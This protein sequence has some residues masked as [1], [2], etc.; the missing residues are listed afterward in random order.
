MFSIIYA[1]IYYSFLLGSQLF[2]LHCYTLKPR[3]WCMAQGTPCVWPPRASHT[4][5]RARST[6][7]LCPVI[8]ALSQRRICFNHSSGVPFSGCC[9]DINLN[10]C[11]LLRLRGRLEFHFKFCSLR[12][13]CGSGTDAS[14][15]SRSRLNTEAPCS[16][17][18]YAAQVK[19]AMWL[20]MMS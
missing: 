2:F 18:P 11:V 14:Y 7:P 9:I 5:P 17:N 3:S 8:P 10:V 16:T 15:R 6:I 20:R 12:Q 19:A 4:S 13:L 1:F